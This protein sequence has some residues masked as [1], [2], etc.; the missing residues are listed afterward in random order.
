M[1]KQALF[2]GKLDL[3]L[4]PRPW[5][6]CAWAPYQAAEVLSSDKALVHFLVNFFHPPPPRPS[7]PVLL[8]LLL[9]TDSFKSGRYRDDSLWPD[10]D[11]VVWVKISYAAV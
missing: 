8:F 1:P 4:G 10:L 5:E 11:L 6:G 7:G 3:P 9:N 2:K